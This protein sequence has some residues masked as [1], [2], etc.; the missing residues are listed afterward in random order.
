M[1][2]PR[3]NAMSASEGVRSGV[4]VVVGGRILLLCPG[5]PGCTMGALPGAIFC[6][7]QDAVAALNVAETS[8]HPRGVMAAIRQVAMVLNR[9]MRGWSFFTELA[10]R[11]KLSE[12]EGM[13]LP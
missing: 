8:K 13:V 5:A 12:E 4:G 11:Y 10:F 9:D 3:M 6:C 7:W 1:I 2:M